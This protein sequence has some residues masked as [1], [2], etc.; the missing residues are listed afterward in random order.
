MGK[1]WGKGKGVGV[2]KGRQEGGSWGWGSK[3]S[4]GEMEGRRAGRAGGK[5]LLPP[6][7]RC[8]RFMLREEQALGTQGLKEVLSA[9]RNGNRTA[10]RA[11]RRQ[12]QE[13]TSPPK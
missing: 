10:V 9:R 1:W 3:G 5:G 4:L 7:V 6:S 11:A 2:C 8:P 12:S 13:P